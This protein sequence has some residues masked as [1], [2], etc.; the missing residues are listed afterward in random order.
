MFGGSWVGLAAQPGSNDDRGHNLSEAADPLNSRLD[1][2]VR[3]RAWN[4]ALSHDPVETFP[5]QIPILVDD[6]NDDDVPPIVKEEPNVKRQ[7]M[8]QKPGVKGVKKEPSMRRR[9]RLRSN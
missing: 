2:A 8:M 6:G 9:N 7:S 3:D 1:R 4:S 5:A